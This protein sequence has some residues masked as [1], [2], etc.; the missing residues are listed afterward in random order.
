MCP[1][2]LPQIEDLFPHNRATHFPCLEGAVAHDPPGTR[3]VG[4]WFGGQAADIKSGA[5]HRPAV[6]LWGVERLARKY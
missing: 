6:T 2:V 5:G 1:S 4:E 3:L